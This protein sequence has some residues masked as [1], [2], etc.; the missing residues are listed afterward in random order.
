[1]SASDKHIGDDLILERMHASEQVLLTQ[2]DA[3]DMK[4]SYLL[5]VLVFLAQLSGTFLSTPNLGSLGKGSQ[6]LSC[7]YLF[8]SGVFLFLELRVKTFKIEDVGHFENWRDRVVGRRKGQASIETLRT[9]TTF[10][11]AG[12]YGG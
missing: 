6:C 5:V 1:M 9:P 10:C 8:V 3:L 2:A 12:W 4:A 7:L 11:T